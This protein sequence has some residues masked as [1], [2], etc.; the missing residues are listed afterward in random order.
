MWLC[1]VV[2]VAIFLH[3][4]EW[5]GFCVVSEQKIIKLKRLTG[6]EDIVPF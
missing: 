2:A 6:V 4:K 5:L 3:V 1:V